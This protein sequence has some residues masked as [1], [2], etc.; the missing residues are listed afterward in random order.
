MQI[1]AGA[2]AGL[3]VCGHSDDVMEKHNVW[4]SGWNGIVRVPILT[5]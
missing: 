3:P 4:I 2:A 1:T 5:V